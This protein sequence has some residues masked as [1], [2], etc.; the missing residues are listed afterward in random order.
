ME[1][2]LLPGDRG[3]ERFPVLPRA[4]II[5]SNYRYPEIRIPENYHTPSRQEIKETLRINI[6]LLLLYYCCP[7]KKNALE[8]PAKTF[9]ARLCNTAATNSNYAAQMLC[10]MRDNGYRNRQQYEYWDSSLDSSVGVTSRRRVR[11]DVVAWKIT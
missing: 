7:P 10:V 1:A 4:L 11:T 8:F 6:A 2:L 3:R 9:D 5:S